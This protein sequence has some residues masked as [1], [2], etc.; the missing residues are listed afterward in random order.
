MLSNDKYLK[1][2]RAP[3][4]EVEASVGMVL[5]DN[6][7]KVSL[8]LSKGIGLGQFSVVMTAE[9]ASEL[10]DNLRYYVDSVYIQRM[11]RA[12]NV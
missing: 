2:Y 4:E 6:V 7:H 9:E 12:R 5:H 11:K 1:T 10:M 8:R 3:K